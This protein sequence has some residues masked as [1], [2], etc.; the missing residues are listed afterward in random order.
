M[1]SVRSYENKMKYSV[2]EMKPFSYINKKRI[3]S[4]QRKKKQKLAFSNIH[5]LLLGEGRP[6]AEEIGQTFEH[7]AITQLACVNSSQ[8]EDCQANALL[9]QYPCTNTLSSLV[10]Y[11]RLRRD[12]RHRRHAHWMGDNSNSCPLGHDKVLNPQHQINFTRI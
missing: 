2:G 5:R 6:A 8:P 12:H 10:S 7:I 9:T 11:V 4:E 3:Q 1:R